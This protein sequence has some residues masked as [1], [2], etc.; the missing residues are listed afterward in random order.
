VSATALSLSC[1]LSVYRLA[2]SR[3]RPCFPTRRSSDLP[4][5]S[6]AVLADGDAV[7]LQS[8]DEGARLLLLAGKP[9]KEPIVQYGPFVMNTSER[10]EEHTSELQS[11]ENL[12]CR[13]LVEKTNRR[14]GMPYH[15]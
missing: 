8:G 9:I 2:V 15:G 4:Q 10:S 6:A 11:R 14:Q 13:L 3:G 12:V 1:G 5:H 7:T